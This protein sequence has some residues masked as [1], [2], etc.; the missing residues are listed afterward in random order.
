MSTRA[1]TLTSTTIGKKAVMAA[2]G[3]I[4]LLFAI[5]HLTGN[6]KAFQGARS[7]NEYAAF[8]RTLGPLL[9]VARGAILVSFLVHVKAAMDLWQRNKQAGAGAARYHGQKKQKTDWAA[10]SMYLSGPGLLVYILV[11][12][13]HLTF[14]H[15]LFG[16][17]AVL[18]IEGYVF[19]EMN[20]FNNMVLGF[21]VWWIAAFYCVGVIGLGIHLFHG[22]W[23]MFQTAGANH[24]RYNH[25]RRD[26]A[27]ILST[28][29]TLGYLSI[30]I[31][32]LAGLIEPTNETFFF[33]ELKH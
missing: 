22:I 32:T 31:A 12:L 10:L 19:D 25:L 28:L 3:A 18:G 11:H 17:S 14:G 7:F 29:L 2:S 27:I 1:L 4:M 26:L 9:W 15:Y 16:E 30:P 21:Q 5:G 33:P 13:A 8:L 6:L 24:P 23:S 20:P